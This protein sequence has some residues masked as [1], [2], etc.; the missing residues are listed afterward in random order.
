MLDKLLIVNWVNI[1]TEINT[2]S[3]IILCFTEF[4]RRMCLLF[5]KLNINSTG[6][7]LLYGKGVAYAG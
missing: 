4:I 5:S 3:K 2:Q 6:R 1:T 7:I